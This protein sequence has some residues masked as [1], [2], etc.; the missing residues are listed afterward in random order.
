VAFFRGWET[1]SAEDKIAAVH[2][3]KRVLDKVLDQK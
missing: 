1:F 2:D 3:A